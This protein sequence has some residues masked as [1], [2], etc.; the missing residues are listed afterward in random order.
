M[1]RCRHRR[2]HR[3]RSTGSGSTRI[4][5]DARAD[6]WPR[7][8]VGFFTKSQLTHRFGS[9]TSGPLIANLLRQRR[10]AN[11]EREVFLSRPAWSSS[12]RCAALR[13]APRLALPPV[14]RWPT[15]RLQLKSKDMSDDERFEYRQKPSIRKRSAIR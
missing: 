13:A 7:P 3:W 15:P 11:H 9:I 14:M 12:P 6:A 5:A 4:T 8:D 10:R 1:T 2:D